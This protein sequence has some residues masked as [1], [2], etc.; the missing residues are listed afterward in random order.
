MGPTEAKVG[1][2]WGL[3]VRA[4]SGEVLSDNRHYSHQRE[5]IRGFAGVAGVARVAEG[6]R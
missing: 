2:I 3:L 4:R 1:S 5:G 6:C